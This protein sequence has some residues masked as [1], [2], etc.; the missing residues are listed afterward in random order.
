MG[1]P[2]QPTPGINGLSWLALLHTSSLP[3]LT[4]SQTQPEPKRVAAALQEGILEV[5]EASE[6][7]VNR[8]GEVTG[9]R[10]STVGRHARPEQVVVQ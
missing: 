6:V 3:S 10:S 4:Q 5:L 2:P 9:G 7:A 1:L 8:C